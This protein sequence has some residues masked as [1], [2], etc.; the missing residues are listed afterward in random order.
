MLKE[1]DK[2]P[3][4]VDTFSQLNKIIPPS[5]ISKYYYCDNCEKDQK[6]EKTKKK[7]EEETNKCKHSNSPKVVPYSFL[8]SYDNYIISWKTALYP[9]N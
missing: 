4:K 7:K 6:E 5:K 3:E 8:I 9:A 2:L 1:E